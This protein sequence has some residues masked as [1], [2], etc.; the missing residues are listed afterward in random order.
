M[1][2]QAP[3]ILDVSV[4]IDRALDNTPNLAAVFLISLRDGAPYLARTSMLQRRL[5]RLLRAREGPSRLLNLRG[6]ASR[7][8]FWPT[9]SRLESSLVFYEL[10]LRHHPEDYLKLLRLR[11]P[12][13]VRVVLASRFPRTTVTT[14]LS[15]SRSLHYGPFR[16][17]TAA[18]LFE[19]QFL[20]L[21]QLRRCQENLE[22]SPAHPGC[23]YGE[24]GKCL[25]PCQDLVSDEE[26]ASE[27]DRV[28][29]FL[30]SGG[31]SMLDTIMHQRDRLSA[32]LQFEAAA[33][34]HKQLERVQQIL[35][36][37]DELACDIE[38]L[39]GVAVMPS[40][41]YNC[42][43][44]WFVLRG[45]FLPPRRF[46]FE[47]VEGKTVS[48]DS[49][50]R[51]IASALEQPKLSKQRRQEHIALLARWYYSSWRD[52]EWVGFDDVAAIPWRRLVNAIH[53]VVTATVP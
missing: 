37:R 12:P 17:R 11:M 42:V 23:I 45:C 52:G 29:E 32:E 9:A 39:S 8:E 5:K 6:I 28:V 24:M 36:L 10:A 30:S 2:L 31:R 22:P 7:V 50:L 4:D 15:A 49:R 1:N 41:K 19:N 44:L 35:R 27:A 51:E 3:E 40:T 43:E 13:F 33:H 38:R 18:E 20:D 14:K 47:V 53:R 26:Y 16:T 34:E 48:L 21:F 25:R 46:G